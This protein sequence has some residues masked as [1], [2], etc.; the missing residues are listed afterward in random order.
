MCV[1]VLGA[2]L[3]SVVL[4]G[5]RSNEENTLKPPQHRA[6]EKAEEAQECLLVGRSKGPYC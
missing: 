2:S 4:L 5:S 6:E 3:N 1:L